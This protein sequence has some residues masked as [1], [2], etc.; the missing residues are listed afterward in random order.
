[1]ATETRTETGTTPTT[2]EQ[3]APERREGG[4]PL[5]TLRSEIDAL[6]DDFLWGWPSGRSGR[7][8]APMHRLARLGALATVP[9]LDVEDRDGEIVVRAELPGMDEK[10]V[11]VRL[12]DG[13]LT[14]SGEKRETEERGGEEANYY[15][16]ERRFGSFQRSLPLPEGIAHD[17]VEATFSKGVLTVTLP[18]TEE[19]K[20]RAR[21]I[22][23]RAS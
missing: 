18:K 7:R 13:T 12:S 2:R 1:M 22:E 16:S 20:S 9:A 8:G 19:A 11:D 21:R 6:F 3:T 17:R 5:A 10:D 14:I 15:V 4:S 23:V